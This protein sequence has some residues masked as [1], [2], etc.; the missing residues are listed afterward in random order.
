LENQT[1]P[2]LPLISDN[3]TK[4]TNLLTDLVYWGRSRSR[5]G[6]Y[7]ASITTL[8]ELMRGV[9]EDASS[10]MEMKNLTVSLP[11]SKDNA[12]ICVDRVAATVVFRNILSNAVKFSVHGGVITIAYPVDGE[13]QGLSIRDKGPGIPESIRKQVTA[14]HPVTSN[15]GSSGEKGMGMGLRIVTSI[16]WANQWKIDILSDPSSGTEVTIWFPKIEC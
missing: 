13:R 3:V 5:E 7:D 10:Y 2:A 4:A 6:L 14:G 1:D 16:C 9:I 12:T 15:T 8:N 11:E